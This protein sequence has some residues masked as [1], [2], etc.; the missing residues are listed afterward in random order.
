VDGESRGLVEE[1]HGP[2]LVSVVCAV[3]QHEVGE[4][5]VECVGGECTYN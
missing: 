3:G 2:V 4:D 5:A 1:E